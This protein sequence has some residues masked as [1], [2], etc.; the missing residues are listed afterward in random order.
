MVIP[1]GHSTT[2]DSLLTSEPVIS[3]LGDFPAN[4]F[5]SKEAERGWPGGP[6]MAWDPTGSQELPAIDPDH[7]RSLVKS[8]FDLAHTEFPIIHQASFQ[9]LLEHKLETGL[10]QDTDSA[11]ILVVL[12]VGNIAAEPR[13]VDEDEPEES[14]PSFRYI[15]PALRI[16][17]HEAINTFGT[18]VTLS[19]GLFLASKFYGYLLRPLQSWKLVYMA[20]TNIQHL[21]NQD[22]DIDWPDTNDTALTTWAIFATECD[23]IAEHQ[24][25]RSGIEHVVDTMPLPKSHDQGSDA[26]LSFL[27][28]LAVRRLLNRVHHTI[29]DKRSMN[30]S[31]R[32]TT[33]STQGEPFQQQ[34]VPAVMKVSTEL[35]RQLDMWFN[36][37]PAS[38]RPDLRD[39]T[40]CDNHT[41]NLLHRYYSARDIIFR[42]FVVYAWTLA[43]S[44]QLP[45]QVLACCGA[46]LRSCRSYLLTAIDSLSSVRSNKEI[47]IH[48]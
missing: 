23:L 14:H 32:V 26:S 39:R 31:L 9:V 44:R 28:E 18:T 35:D 20:S 16:L 3:T 43:P 41:S 34:P 48:S 2:T 21:C 24:L 33:P 36:L 25:P 17:S 22:M 27:A 40:L 37:L 46:C 29:Y 12:A 42:P 5:L 11:L 8:F 47:L 7:A 6:L 30:L 38:I 10:R 1:R 13:T 45:D 4:L 15:I 19:Q